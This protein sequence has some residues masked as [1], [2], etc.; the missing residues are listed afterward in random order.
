MVSHAFL[1]VLILAASLYLG[2][3]ARNMASSPLIPWSNDTAYSFYSDGYLLR[4]GATPDLSKVSTVAGGETDGRG[5]SQNAKAG[6]GLGHLESA[7]GIQA[8]AAQ[9][10]PAGADGE[11]AGSSQASST[12]A[13]PEERGIISYEVAPGDVVSTIAERFG[14]STETVI[15]ANNLRNADF[16]RLGE[17]L[18]ILPISGLLHTVEKGDSLLYLAS[19]YGVDTEE[20]VGYRV[21]NIANPDSLAIGQKLI[22]P[23]GTMPAARAATSTRGVARP[24]AEA[25]VG[26]APAQANSSASGQFIWPNSGR[27]TQYFSGAHSGLD[28]AAPYGT[29]VAAAD[30]GV[31]VDRAAL[32]WG[33]GWYVTLDHGNGYATTYA[34]LSSFAVVIGE[35]VDKGDMIGRVG[36][37]GNS[38]GPHN[39][40]V[41]RRNGVP[42]NPLSVLP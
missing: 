7:S 29:P 1:F 25:A 18:V 13:A 15:S 9:A 12:D 40:F 31:V 37:T 16:L 42:I 38:T 22:I 14:I 28:V 33:L 19:R 20:I 27:I 8:A 11:Q 26:A 10:I 32:N 21:N 30:G 3:S 23:G 4:P 39:H 17:S 36:S 5:A 24:A 6:A 2:L 34:H 35:R 41:V